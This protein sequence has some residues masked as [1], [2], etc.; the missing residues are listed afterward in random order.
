MIQV[1]CTVLLRRAVLHNYI[2][3]HNQKAVEALLPELDL[4]MEASDDSC[5]VFIA[6]QDVT[7]FIRTPQVIMLYL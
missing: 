5:K 2:D 7:D 3:V 4:T 1:L 6:G